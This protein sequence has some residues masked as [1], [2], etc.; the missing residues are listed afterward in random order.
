[1]RKDLRFLDEAIVV[2]NKTK[3]LAATN[4]AINKKVK[5]LRY[6]L[7]KKRNIVYRHS[8]TTMFGRGALNTT[9]FDTSSADKHVIWTVELIFLRAQKDA[10]TDSSFSPFA[11]CDQAAQVVLNNE[12]MIHEET[13]LNSFIA[14]SHLKKTFFNEQLS[15]LL[16]NMSDEALQNSE[17]YMKRVISETG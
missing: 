16:T 5:N 2:S 4:P 9:Y 1:M 15:L 12:H 10:P 17:L 7:R 8:P 3:K 11:H 6:F 13:T 14:K